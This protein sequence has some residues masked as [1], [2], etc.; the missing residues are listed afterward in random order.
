MEAAYGLSITLTML[1]T[2][3]LLAF[4][5]LKKRVNRMYILGFLLVYLAIELGFF[6]ANIINRKIKSGILA[7]K[8]EGRTFLGSSRNGGVGAF[9]LLVPCVLGWGVFL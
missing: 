9:R 6:S 5:L 7:E 3:L 8:K 1:M 4:W 2:T